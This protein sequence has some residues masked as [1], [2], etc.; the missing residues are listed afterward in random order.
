MLVQRPRL[1][2]K[3]VAAGR[4]AEE[5]HRDSCPLRG[6]PAATKGAILQGRQSARIIYSDDHG[7]TWKAGA[8]VNDNRNIGSEVINSETMNNKKEQ[9]TETSVVQLSNGQ[10]KLFMRGYK[11]K[12]QVATSNDGGVTWENDIKIYDIPEVGVQ[13]S[14]ITTV[15]DGQEYVVLA[16]ANGGGR[17]NGY[18]RVA[19]VESSGELTWIVNKRIQ[20]GKYAYNSLQQIGD[21]EFGILY[22]HAERGQ[23]EFT[24]SFKKFQWK[25]IIA[26]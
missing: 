4:A 5:F 8:A 18:I 16:N 13:M 11:G 1:L 20:N 24:L 21:T 26:P 6:S 25:E 17:N 14:A 7:V 9:N 3:A 10:L 19:K 15:Q 12:L 2:W 22:E 23:N